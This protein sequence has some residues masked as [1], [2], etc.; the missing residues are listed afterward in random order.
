M[1]R[2]PNA[3][4]TSGTFSGSGRAFG[5]ERPNQDLEYQNTGNR[6]HAHCREH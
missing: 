3:Q 6:A 5:Q 4:K 1:I 2:S